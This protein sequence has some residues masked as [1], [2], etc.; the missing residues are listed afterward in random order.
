MYGCPWA[1]ILFNPSRLSVCVHKN[2]L[3]NPLFQSPFWAFIPETHLFAW[4]SCVFE[5]LGPRLGINYHHIA[6]IRVIKSIA[7]IMNQSLLL[8]IIIILF[9]NL[10]IQHYAL[11]SFFFYLIKHVISLVIVAIRTNQSFVIETSYK[12]SIQIIIFN[13]YS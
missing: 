7:F 2:L 4:F 11:Y 6:F 9:F 5:V 8:C 3:D 1:K 13:F 12:Y 10:I